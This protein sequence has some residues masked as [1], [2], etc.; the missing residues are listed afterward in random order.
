MRV[1]GGDVDPT[2]G[3]ADVVSASGGGV[4][5]NGGPAQRGLDARRRA[6]PSRWEMWLHALVGGFLLL[7]GL[8]AWSMLKL[9]VPE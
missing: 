4:G 8:C 6:D 3:V 7:L 5:R 2:S 9:K 1:C